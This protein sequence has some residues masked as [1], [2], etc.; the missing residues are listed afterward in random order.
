MDNNDYVIEFVP[1]NDQ[2]TL[3]PL[4]SSHKGSQFVSS[5][6]SEVGDAQYFWPE[7]AR[8]HLAHE[9]LSLLPS[10]WPPT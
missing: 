6:V 10:V 1:Y 7:G 4:S 9:N 8:E 5:F 3:L 2:N